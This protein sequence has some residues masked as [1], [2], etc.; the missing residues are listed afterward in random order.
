MVV[1][2][3]YGWSRAEEM[4]Y[5]K[6]KKLDRGLNAFPTRLVRSWCGVRK[7]VVW[8]GLGRMSKVA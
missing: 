7:S 3:L 5:N 8:V 2:A 4:E 6:C 1:Y